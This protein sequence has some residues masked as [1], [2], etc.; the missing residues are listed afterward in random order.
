MND[1]KADLDF[2]HAKMKGSYIDVKHE[3]RLG[4]LSCKTDTETET[5]YATANR[6]PHVLEHTFRALEEQNDRYATSLQFSQMFYFC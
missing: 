6:M 4:F 1:M 3:S 2:Y 5:E